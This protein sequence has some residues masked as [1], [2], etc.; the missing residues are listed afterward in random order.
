MLKIRMTTFLTSKAHKSEM[1]KYLKVINKTTKKTKKDSKQMLL[2]IKERCDD[3][4]SP[5]A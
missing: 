2:N 1:L 4:N 3:L 5:N